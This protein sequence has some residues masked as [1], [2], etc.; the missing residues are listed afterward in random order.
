MASSWGAPCRADDRSID[1]AAIAYEMGRF[2]ECIQQFQAILQHDSSNGPSTQEGRSRARMY[3]AACQMS[4]KHNEEA[5]AQ[6][7]ELLREN[8]KFSPDRA[9][10]SPS[11]YGRYLTIRGRLQAEIELREQEEQKRIEELRKQQLEQER[12]E[13]ERREQ[14]ER[15]AREQIV[16]QKNSRMVALIPFGV[17]QFQN[18]QRTFGWTLLGAEAT[19]AA[20]SVVTYFLKENIERQ[21][22]ASVNEAE[23]RKLRDTAVQAN[24]LFFGAFVVTMLSGI[25]HAQVTFVP[26]FREIRERALPPMTPPSPTAPPLSP[27]LS[28]G[29]LRWQSVW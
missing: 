26:E 5:D 24:Y 7:E 19:F 29:L 9:A 16:L 23:A 2:E 22:N 13:R 4:L 10:F 1:Q 27:Q 14:V 17:G 3:L 6:F 11:I 18:H 28:G 25:V 8:Y 21:F 15:M 12:L 20:G